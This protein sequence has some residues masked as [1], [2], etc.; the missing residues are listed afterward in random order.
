MSRVKDDHE[1]NLVRDYQTNPKSITLTRTPN[2]QPYTYPLTPN[3]V[4]VD[5]MSPKSITMKPGLRSSPSPRTTAS[6][7]RSRT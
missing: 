7:L 3:Q 4:R 2:P 1:Y 5:Q 6:C